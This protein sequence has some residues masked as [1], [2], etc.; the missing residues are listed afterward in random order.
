MLTPSYQQLHNPDG[1]STYA[2]YWHKQGGV[3]ID[4]I[5]D[6][7][8]SGSRTL[9]EVQITYPD[10]S[11]SSTFRFALISDPQQQK[12]F[13]DQYCEIGGQPRCPAVGIE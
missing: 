9:V 5:Q 8:M 6:L 10:Q 4:N 2:E 3:H 11:D 12:W 13:F 1:Y 7:G